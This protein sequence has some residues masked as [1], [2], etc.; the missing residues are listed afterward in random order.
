MHRRRHG[1][2]P[3]AI[4]HVGVGFAE[5]QLARRHLVQ[6]D[7]EREDVAA[8]ILACAEELLGG[9]KGGG[10]GAESRFLREQIGIARVMRE[11]E[12]DEDDAAVALEND[13]R[14]LQIEMDDI[15]LMKTV[16]RIGDRRADVRDLR[17]GERPLLNEILE[18][19]AFNPLRDEIGRPRE[20]A[21]GDERRDV[22]PLQGRDDRRFR[23]ETDDAFARFVRADARHFH[24]ERL[25]VSGLR[26]AI[27]V[28]H[29]AGVHA[30]ADRET[31]DL[32]AGPQAVEHDQIPRS[33]R[34][35]SNSGR[36]AARI[37][38]AVSR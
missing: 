36:R 8:R 10:A 29:R 13:V 7:A 14:R 23:L 32:R 11:P 25:R 5:R 17:K 30:I 6:H 20:I 38:R 28:A 35:A 15:L 27:D 19:V 22:R 4:A 26:D 9:H 16:Q 3:E 37:F 33:M 21:D 1:I 2:D 18:A 12:V 24:D 31:V 34:S